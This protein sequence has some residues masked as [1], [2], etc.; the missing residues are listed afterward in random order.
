MRLI[1]TKTLELE[2]FEDGWTPPYAILSHTWGSDSEELTF[3]DVKNGITDKPGIGSIKFRECSLRLSVTLIYLTFRLPTT[4][5]FWDLNSGQVG[6]SP[7]DGHYK[8]FLRL[9][10]CGS[11]PQIGIL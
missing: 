6:G 11:I 2:E 1:N 5:L 9:G 7:E 8:N 10:I 3:S 4:P